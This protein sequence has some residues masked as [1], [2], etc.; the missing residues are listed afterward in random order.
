MPDITVLLADDEPHVTHVMARAV[1]A[2]GMEVL[3]AEDGEEAY[4]LA[5][6]HRPQLIVTDLQMPYMSGIDLAAK[7]NGNNELCRIPVILLSARGYVVENEAKQLSNIR[8]V[9]EKPFSARDVVAKIRDLLGLAEPGLR[10][11]A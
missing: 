5:T 6:E 2:A 10:Q 9:I 8:M 4:E 7:L 1:R 3:T 11:S